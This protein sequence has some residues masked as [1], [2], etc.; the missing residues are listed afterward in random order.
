[1][2]QL[3]KEPDVN[4]PLLII[5]IQ[6]VLNW[7]PHVSSLLWFCAPLFYFYLKKIM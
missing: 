6:L 7:L 4:F 1:M 5:V 3:H 2:I